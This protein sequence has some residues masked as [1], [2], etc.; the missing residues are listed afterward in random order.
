MMKPDKEYIAWLA[1]LKQRF[2]LS[3][4]KAAVKVN[5]ELI[6]FYWHLGRDI[7]EKQS[8]SNWGD[9]LIPQLSKDLKLEFPDV[10][11]FS[12]SN[13]KFV[14]RF[15]LFYNQQNTIGYQAGGQLTSQTIAIQN[16]DEE[17]TVVSLQTGIGH[18]VGSEIFSLLVQVP[19]RH[20]VEIITKCKQLDEALFY[21]RKTIQNGWS[22]AMLVHFMEL[23]L[24][25]TEGSA[26]TNFEFTLP[27]PQSDLAQQVLKDP[28]KF[29]FLSLSQDYKEKDLEDALTSRII[30]FL[31]E[32]GTGFAFVGRQ[33]PI[34]VNGEEYKIDLLFYHLLLRC[35]VVVDLKVVK[36]EPEFAGKMGFYI[37]AIDEQVK[38]PIDN[39]TIGLIIC[40]SK[41]DLV[42]RYA[43]KNI[44][45]PIG[46]AEYRLSDSLPKDL[47]DKLPT[48]Q[49]IE[50]EINNSNNNIKNIN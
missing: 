7:V 50:N 31:L 37:S 13:I 42:V 15:Y 41:N 43:L 17:K 16:P 44:N 5:S 33:Y 24:Y 29:E 28:Y 36:F 8:K 19:W 32:M 35:Y 6:A 48:I 23:D 9:G 45:Q 2:R 20:H 25:K 47:K 46:V 1:D 34:E 18:Q 4:I 30:H 3:Q 12:I 39:P 14:K 49:D 38:L 26:I 10:G 22:R 40:K 11:G 27:H 21:V